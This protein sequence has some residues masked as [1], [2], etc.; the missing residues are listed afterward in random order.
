MQKYATYLD[1]N[2][3]YLTY[4]N[5]VTRVCHGNKPNVVQ[6][7]PQI[8]TKSGLTMGNV[9]LIADSTKIS[10]NSSSVLHIVCK[11]LTNCNLE[12]FD[13]SMLT[14]IFGSHLY[15]KM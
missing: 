3:K 13:V 12:C 2:A 4:K 1:L 8:I 14:W 9:L 7:S 6:D 11:A 5:S 10:E 15:P